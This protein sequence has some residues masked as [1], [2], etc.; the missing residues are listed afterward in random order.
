MV[1]PCNE[2]SFQPFCLRSAMTFFRLNVPRSSS[3]DVVWPSIE[4]NTTTLSTESL[5]I[6]R[7]PKRVSNASLLMTRLRSGSCRSDD[8][9]SV[10]TAQ[11][12]TGT[13]RIKEDS[14]PLQAPILTRMT[15]HTNDR[16]S[17]F[18]DRNFVARLIY[19]FAASFCCANL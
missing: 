7:R 10:M 6:P 14:P 12:S 2:F 13:R 19:L 16:S 9:S 4:L 15:V 11:L 17:Q 8:Q 1:W 5:F 3:P 18:C